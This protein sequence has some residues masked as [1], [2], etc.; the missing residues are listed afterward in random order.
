MFKKEEPK[1]LR[2][3]ELPWQHPREPHSGFESHL[4]ILLAMLTLDLNFSVSKIGLIYFLP[5]KRRI[6]GIRGGADMLPKPPWHPQTELPA[7][8]WAV[9]RTLLPYPVSPSRLPSAPRGQSTG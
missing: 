1:R 7:L 5:K 2:P 9:G 6:K 4:Y 3:R 8:C